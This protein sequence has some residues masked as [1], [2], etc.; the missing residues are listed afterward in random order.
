MN[1]SKIGR[2][3]KQKQ[4]LKEDFIKQIREDH[5]FIR[6]EL[7]Y[8]LQSKLSRIKFHSGAMAV[9]LNHYGNLCHENFDD[10]TDYHIRREELEAHEYQRLEDRILSFDIAMQS[11]CD[12]IEQEI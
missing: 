1:P 4:K 6:D 3:I 7:G 12:K 5:E 2:L 11:L 10:L 9:V 8:V